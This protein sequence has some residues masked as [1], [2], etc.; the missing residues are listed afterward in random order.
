[1]KVMYA[2]YLA[3]PDA[4]KT[5]GF[6]RPDPVQ[7]TNLLSI[8]PLIHSPARGRLEYFLCGPPKRSGDA[9]ARLDGSPG[10]SWMVLFRGLVFTDST[11]RKTLPGEQGWPVD[12]DCGPCANPDG[13]CFRKHKTCFLEQIQTEYIVYQG[14]VLFK[15]FPGR[16]DHFRRLDRAG[17]PCKIDSPKA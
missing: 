2:G 5:T 16:A 13:A 15:Q 11:P 14:I 4:G 1:M 12:R 17:L 8:A 9:G 7:E 10:A 6:D 3:N